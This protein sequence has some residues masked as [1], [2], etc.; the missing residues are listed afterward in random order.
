[1]AYRRALVN[2][3]LLVVFIRDDDDERDLPIEADTQISLGELDAQAARELARENYPQASQTCSMRLLQMH[4]ASRTNS[5]RLQRQRRGVVRRVR[6][7]SIPPHAPQSQRNSARY[8]QPQRT[9]LQLLSLSPSRAEAR[10]LRRSIELELL[11]EAISPAR[12]P[13]YNG[14]DLR[15]D[16]NEDSAAATD[17]R[18]IERRGVRTVRERLVFAEQAAREWRPRVRATRHYSISPLPPPPNA[19]C[20]RLSGRRSVI[21]R[22]VNHP[23]NVCPISTRISLPH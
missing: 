10:C 1:M 16:R 12:S 20:A 6:T 2:R 17:H 18:C 4:A 23:T 11:P 3:P 22:W 13:A 9:A 8:P 5:S 14:R 19:R 7:P 21:S 15:D